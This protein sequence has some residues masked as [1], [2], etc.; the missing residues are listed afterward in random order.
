M[1]D[2]VV[3]EGQLS[4]TYRQ[5]LVNNMP[6]GLSAAIVKVEKMFNKA[7]YLWRPSPRMFVMGDVLNE[8]IAWP[9]HSIQYVNLS[10]PLY[11]TASADKKPSP[12][13][14]NFSTLT[15]SL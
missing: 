6:L 1:V 10:P 11:E 2:S 9:L 5:E 15:Y 3:C 8:N 4:S 14:V 12:P 7:A 13:L